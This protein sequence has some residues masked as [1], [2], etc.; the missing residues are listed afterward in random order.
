[1]IVYGTKILSDIALPLDLSHATEYR[2]E[3]K[4]EGQVPAALKERITCGFPLYWAHGRKVYLFSDRLF[5]GSEPG[6]PWCYEVEGVARF[7]WYAGAQSLY[8]E[9]VGQGDDSLLAFWLIHLLL[10]LYLTLEAQYEFLHAGAVEVDGRPV[11]FIAP[12]MGGKS[13]LT[14]YFIQQGHALISDDKVPTYIEG[15][16][17]MA[18]GAHPYHRPYRKYED[19]GYRVENFAETV[20]PIHAV[21]LLNRSEPGDDIRIEEVRGFAKFEALLPNYLYTFSFLK[22]KR[23]KYLSSMLNGIRIYNVNV[24]WDIERL[25]EVHDAIRAHSGQTA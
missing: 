18:V 15:G 20:K 23:L 22:T 24:P 19:L 9:Q 17:F 10:P 11:L 16:C 1:M 8:Y 2:Y 14:D 25:C 21:Y 13:T 7:Y 12:S 3:L 5:D 4:L 6:Q